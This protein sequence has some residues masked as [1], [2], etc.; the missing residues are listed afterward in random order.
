MNKLRHLDRNGRLPQTVALR[1]RTLPARIWPVTSRCNRR[2]RLD[3]TTGST[4]PMG[5]QDPGAGRGPALSGDVGAQLRTGAGSVMSLNRSARRPSPALCWGPPVCG[6]DDRRDK[7]RFTSRDKHR[8][9]RGLILPHDAGTNLGGRVSLSAGVA[10]GGR[11][12]Q[13]YNA[14]DIAMAAVT[15]FK[16]GRTTSPLEQQCHPR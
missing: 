15:A 1:V 11:L 16:A 6:Q 10:N 14:S 3:A 4:G 2:L 7:W 5:R 9:A 8:P 13:Q 12:H